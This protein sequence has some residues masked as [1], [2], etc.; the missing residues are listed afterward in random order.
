MPPKALVKILS[1]GPTS[2]IAQGSRHHARRGAVTALAEGTSRGKI[3]VSYLDTHSRLAFCFA[4]RIESE[5]RQTFYV[6]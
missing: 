3:I 4:A 1:S 6:V 2:C 5:V